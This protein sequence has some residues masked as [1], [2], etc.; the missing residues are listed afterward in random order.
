MPYNDRLRLTMP[1]TLHYFDTAQLFVRETAKK[2]GFTGKALNEIDLAIEEAV[3][4]VMKHGYDPEENAEFDLM[5]ERIPDGIEIIIKEHG[6]PFD[7]AQAPLYKPADDIAE[8]DARGLGL[9][10]LRMTMDDVAFL[11]LGPE[12]RETRLI[13]YLHGNAQQKDAEMQAIEEPRVLTEKI[14]Y[15]VRGLEEKEALEVSKCAWKSHGYSFFDDHI[16]FPERLVAMNKS[17]ELVSAV[18]VTSD[19]VF[20]GHGAFLYQYAD[21]TIAELTFIFVNVEYR[22]QGALNRL[23]EYLFTVPRTRRLD[24]LY[25]Y[26]VANHV[27]T[28]KAMLKY[29]IND[30]GILLATSPASWKFKG[31]SDDTSQRISVILEF[32]YMEEPVVK[33]LYAPEHHLDMIKK[34]YANIGASH[35]WSKPAGTV[36]E[37]KSDTTELFTGVNE[38]EGCAE[39]FVDAYGADYLLA[40]RK[41]LKGFC[42]KGISALNLFLNL[43]DPLTWSLTSEIE[44]LGFFFAGI[45]PCSRIGDALILQYMNNLDFDYGRIN[46]YS[47]VS[48]ELVEYIKAHDPNC[49]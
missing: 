21:D 31:I 47:D 3:T 30:C 12:G 39:I 17:G 36:P 42:V 10:L 2:F 32:K 34:L 40:I 48:K 25:A 41:A 49:F 8:A 15:S 28:Q 13:K 35:T 9:H 7:P 20:M 23:L 19:N 16:Y 11:N 38:L 22:G 45:L 6:I 1:N 24:G 18:A 14:E 27:F 43:E 44:K 46:A 29:G 33:K 4:N 37:F 5:C 26:A